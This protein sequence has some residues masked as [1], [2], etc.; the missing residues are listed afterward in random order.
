MCVCVC[1][2]TKLCCLVF[3]KVC[4]V[5][6]GKEQKKITGFL[7]VPASSCLATQFVPC[8]MVHVLFRWFFPTTGTLNVVTSVLEWSL[9]CKCRRSEMTENE[10]LYWDVD[11]TGAL[12]S[13]VFYTGKST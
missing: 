6:S 11:W 13:T 12:E 1:V 5:S 4:S 3:E 2:Y 7:P 9:Q 10:S 8:G